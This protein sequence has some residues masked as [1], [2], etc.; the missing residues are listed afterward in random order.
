[1]F[2]SYHCVDFK[3]RSQGVVPMPGH[4]KGKKPFNHVGCF[5]ITFDIHFSDTIFVFAKL[6]L[7]IIPPVCIPKFGFI[8]IIFWN[9]YGI[10]KKKFV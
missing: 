1:M 5:L 2:V 9:D 3:P 7:N 6:R 8:S 4:E 10:F